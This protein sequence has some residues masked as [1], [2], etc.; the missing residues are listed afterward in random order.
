MKRVLIVEDELLLAMI[1]QHIVEEIG[2]IVMDILTKG[3]EAIEYVQSSVPDV[4]LM[5]IFLE[6]E[7]DGITAMEKIR[8]FS[9][10]PVIYITGN[11]DKSAVKR[12]KLTNFHGFLVKPIEAVELQNLIKNI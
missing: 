2:C 11:S 10:I 6:G 3:E 5:D 12:A 7:I 9:R 1:N 4:I 8:K